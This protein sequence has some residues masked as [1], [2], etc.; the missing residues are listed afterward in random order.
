MKNI[1]CLC[2]LAL[3]SSVLAVNSYPPSNSGPPTSAD[4][5]TEP[6]V[7]WPQAQPNPLEE[8]N[9]KNQQAPEEEPNPQLGPQPD[10]PEPTSE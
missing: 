5:L 6:P 9:L 10:D 1:L 8:Y 4:F 7:Y 3:S 2:V